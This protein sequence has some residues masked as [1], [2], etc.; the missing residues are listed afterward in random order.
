MWVFYVGVM[1]SCLFFFFS[2]I[3]NILDNVAILHTNTLLSGS[4]FLFAYL[5]SGLAELF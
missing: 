2:W 3:L 5:F 4:L 1:F